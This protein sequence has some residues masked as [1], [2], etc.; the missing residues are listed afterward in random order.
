MSLIPMWLDL[1]YPTINKAD[2]GNT[3]QLSP[4]TLTIHSPQP[5]KIAAAATNSN[6]SNVC[7]LAADLKIHQR[8]LYQVC[9]SNSSKTPN[10][11]I[12]RL[13]ANSTQP[14]PQED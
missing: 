7:N 3:F 14:S 12:E 1:S 8:H 4:A 11:G 6:S 9:M 13:P 10:A 2:Y 5:S